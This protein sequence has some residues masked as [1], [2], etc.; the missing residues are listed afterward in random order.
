VR[1]SKACLRK[2]G[3]P[4][5][6]SKPKNNSKEVEEKEE[7][8]EEEEEEEGSVLLLDHVRVRLLGQK[9]RRRR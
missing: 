4:R 8:E 5:E 3:F 7:E 9:R 6:H 1:E 2:A